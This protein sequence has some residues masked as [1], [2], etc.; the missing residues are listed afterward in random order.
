VYAGYRIAG[1]DPGTVRETILS[2]ADVLPRSN[3]LVLIHGEWYTVM[4]VEHRLQDVNYKCY[5][6]QPYNSI[7]VFDGFPVLVLIKGRTT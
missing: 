2:F 3:E 1:D 6:P 4:R 7:Q 5:I